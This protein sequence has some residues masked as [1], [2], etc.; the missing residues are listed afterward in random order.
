MFY[1]SEWLVL[2]GS[3]ADNVRIQRGISFI[4]NFIYDHRFFVASCHIRQ[5]AKLK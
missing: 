3:I 1:K 2:Q 5:N 4:G